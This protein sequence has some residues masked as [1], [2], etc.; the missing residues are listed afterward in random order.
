MLSLIRDRR[1][2]PLVSRPLLFRTRTLVDAAPPTVVADA[3]HVALIDRRV[4]HVVN[5]GD[6]HVVDGAVVEKV[7]AVPTPALITAAEVA[8]AIVDPAIKSD[9]RAPETFIENK[10]ATTPAP[11][12]G[13]P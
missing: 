5:H 7:S 6:V 10:S 8:V 4:V 9:H 3:R 1:N 12:S 13:S 11:I 2:A